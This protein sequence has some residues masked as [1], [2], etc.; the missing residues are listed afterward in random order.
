MSSG[1]CLVASDLELVR[2]MADSSATAWV[3]IAEWALVSSLEERSISLNQNAMLRK[4]TGVDHL[5]RN[6]RLSL[7]TWR[8][9]LG[10]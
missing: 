10:I 1:C 3:T 5:Y 9:L 8:G 6:R 2:E 4:L 7:Q